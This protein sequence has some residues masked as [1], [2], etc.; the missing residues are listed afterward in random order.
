MRICQTLL[1]NP[2]EEKARI[3]SSRERFG[4]KLLIV[5][6]SIDSPREHLLAEMDPQ[7]DHRSEHQHAERQI[8]GTL[9]AR[10][11]S[12]MRCFQVDCV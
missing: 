7:L 11:S 12:Q 10:L 3:A 8:D 2:Q 6:I 1:A 4:F 9:R 5:A